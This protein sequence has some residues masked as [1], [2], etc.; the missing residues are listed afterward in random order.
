MGKVGAHMGGFEKEDDFIGDVSIKNMRCSIEELFVE[1]RNIR[2]RLDKQAYLL[3]KYLTYLMESTNRTLAY[4]ANTEGFDSFSEL[5]G[6]C[7]DIIRREERNTDRPFYEQAED[8]IGTNPLGCME[9]QTKVSLYTAML[10]GYYL[11]AMATKSYREQ[12]SGLSDVLDIIDLRQLYGR[13]CELLGSEEEMKHI[14][15][16]IRQTFLLVTP[17]ACYLQGMANGLLYDLISRDRESSK[18]MFQLLLD[19]MA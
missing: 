15:R 4:E 8:F 14:D 1:A 9:V 11:E 18:L 6:I 17:M 16:L 7:R 19:R 12:K 13:I 2:R 10:L 3:D 5:R